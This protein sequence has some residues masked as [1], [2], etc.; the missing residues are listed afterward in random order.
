M[1]SSSSLGVAMLAM[2]P[3]EICVDYSV[4]VGVGTMT[5]KG[6]GMCVMYCTVIIVCLD[7]C[8]Q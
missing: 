8:A 7:V 5:L 4:I 6:V 3:D 2:C 1:L